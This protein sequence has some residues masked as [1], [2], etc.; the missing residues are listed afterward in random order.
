MNHPRS[1]SVVIV[2]HN[3]RDN[4]APLLRRIHGLLAEREHEILVVDVGSTDGMARA[5]E[6]LSRELPGI[7]VLNRHHE[8]LGAALRAGYEEARHE[9]IVSTGADLSFSAS[10]ILKLLAQIDAGADLALGCR[11]ALGGSY[12]ARDGRGRFRSWVSAWGNGAVGWMTQAGIWDYTANFRAIKREVWRGL[13]T[14]EKTNALLIEMVLK[15]NR[16]GHRVAQ[17]PGVLGR[18]IH[19]E[20]MI[21]LGVEV[22]SLLPKIPKY[23]W[24]DDLRDLAARSPATAACLAAILAAFA[25]SAGWGMR[26]DL[27]HS[28]LATEVEQVHFALKYGSGDLNPHLFEHP[29]LWSYALFGLYGAAFLAGLASGAFQSVADMER[30]VFTDP[31]LFFI[32]ARLAILLLATGALAF[33]YRLSSGLYPGRGV[34]LLATAF[35]GASATH[36][37][38]AHYSSTDIP[39]MVMSLLAFGAVAEVLRGGGPPAYAAAGLLT[40][41]ATAT[42]YNAAWLA[43]AL[44]LAHALRPRPQAWSLRQ[45][46]WSRDLALGLALVPLG[47]L[48]G[49]PFALLDWRKF[50][51]DYSAAFRNE[52]STDY[53][54]GYRQDRPPWPVYL[55]GTFFP[56]VMGWPMTAAG[57]AG[58]AWAIRRRTRPDL[59]LLGFVLTY[60]AYVGRW[61]LLYPHYFVH[62]LPFVFLLA[63]RACVEATARITGPYGRILSIT[64]LWLAL[65]W[66]S[67]R[68]IASWDRTVASKPAS[69]Q[70]KDWFEEH[71]PP[72]SGVAVNPGIPILPNRTSIERQLREITARS[73]GAGVRL[74][75]QLRYVDSSSKTFDVHELPFPWRDDFLP[76]KFDFRSLR[77]S[78]VRFVLA[79]QEWE[80][81]LADPRRYPEQVAFHRSVA[82]SCR[83]LRRFQGGFPDVS[84]GLSGMSATDFVEVYDCGPAGDNRPAR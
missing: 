57:L 82:S 44:V 10:D 69:R 12:E 61:R 39:M 22:L 35:M 79:S 13:C 49:C 15:A 28:R 45:A 71:A 14:G 78:G 23:T 46:V 8:G 37:A 11:H 63:A 27:P 33:F 3:E 26:S 47:F 54:F 4:I 81:Y 21:N 18:R 6:E 31:T 48:I 19:G 74:R 50:L 80:W 2:A 32:L 66:H 76:E 41:L 72:G 84:F 65:T 17:V 52:S 68:L 1:V 56:T 34:A 59:L 9:V 40:G 55:L 60:T 30:L 53:F 75:R 67:G 51:L 20:S 38:M 29:P 62:V 83:L 16:A 7:R 43:V 5:V 42:K 58:L 64:L 73:L 70:A 24:W 77:R 25:V 36:V